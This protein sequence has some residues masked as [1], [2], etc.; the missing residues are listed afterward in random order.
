MIQVYQ[1][2]AMELAIR[3][4]AQKHHKFIVYR[5]YFNKRKIPLRQNEIADIPFVLARAWDPFFDQSIEMWNGEGGMLLYSY[6][7]RKHVHLNAEAA[8]FVEAP[9]RH[10]EFE[11]MTRGIS[12]EI[13]VYRPPTW[14]LHQATLEYHNP[15]SNHYY[16]LL[17][18]IHAM[19]GRDL[20]GRLGGAFEQSGFKDISK[21]AVFES[22][23]IQGITG[24]DDRQLRTMLSA[25]G[26]RRKHIRYHCYTP[27]VEPDDLEMLYFY[28]KLVDVPDAYKGQRMIR[29][30]TLPEGRIVGFNKY[31]K[32]LVR[33]KYV[34]KHPNIYIL[35]LGYRPVDYA[36]IDALSNARRG[37]WFK[38]QNLVDQSPEYPLVHCREIQLEQSESE[39]I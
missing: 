10:I 2:S 3:E 24:I 6:D 35:E 26:F 34:I 15:T 31:L 19:M 11:E 27:V 23:E 5:N 20:T 1:T 25:Y 33:E 13:V 17:S 22:S 21:V 36:L 32:R 16:T 29:F 9:I 39:P 18:V 38:M 14:H 7:K 4:M 28:N 12:R 8:L 30:D 37:D